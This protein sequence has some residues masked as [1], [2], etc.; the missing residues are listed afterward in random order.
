MGNFRKDFSILASLISEILSTLRYTHSLRLCGI[1]APEQPPGQC[2][3]GTTSAAL[4][5]R[6]QAWH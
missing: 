2:P 4:A 5:P 6:G 1:D 3:V